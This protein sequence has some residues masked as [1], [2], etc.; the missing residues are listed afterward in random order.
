MGTTT[1]S[2][3]S[4]IRKGSAGSALAV[5][6]VLAIS[7]TSP[8]RSA[9]VTDPSVCIAERTGSSVS[10]IWLDAGGHHV[11]RRDG[12]Y[13]ADVGRGVSG[14]T[15]QA[16][17]D[18]ATYEVRTWDGGVR[19]DRTCAGGGAA[20]G[21]P[22]GDTECWVERAGAT[23]TVRWID[24]GGSHVVRRNGAWLASPGSGVAAYTDGSATSG[25][26]YEVR[27]WRDGQRYDRSCSENGTAPTPN[28]SP[29][30]SSGSA[31]AERVIHVSIDG[32]RADHVTPALMPN[33]TRL[34]NQG[35]STLNARTD[36]A[37]TQTLPNHTSMFTGRPV[38]GGSGH[39]VDYNTDKGKTVHQETGGYVASVFDV[40][41]DRGGST[42]VYAGKSKFDMVH[43]T[44][45]NNGAADHVG[46]NNGRDKIDEYRQISPSAAVDRLR[47]ALKNRGNLEYVFFHIRNPDNAGHDHN[48][49]S[50]QYRSAVKEADRILGQ[51]VSMIEGNSAW[52]NATAIIVVA[53]HG[54][55]TGQDLHKNPALG[56]NYTIPFVVWGPG[57]K[58]GADLY[59]LNSGDR[60]N[61][62][63]A[64]VWLGGIQ[65]IRNGEVANLALDF[66][67]YP[68]VPGSTH[69]K[70]Q[71]LDVN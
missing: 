21:G 70:R 62:G 36:P 6:G 58:P 12:A 7:G 55:P 31:S 68:A 51:V 69:N 52:R 9:S 33:L 50:P 40:V 24:N 13:L 30:P 41:H 17:P 66:L 26:T 67:G 15:D 63:S 53:D 20:N 42:S 4:L 64:R 11:I 5:A 44:W 3:P 57:V 60:K 59:A 28:P 43:R 32:L 35:A 29:T 54:G 47:T 34:R 18:G 22:V 45:G 37:R 56:G 61:P 71:D 1:S 49:G 16:A 10:L 38:D 2:R 48:W 8:V 23:A 14:Y 25:S 46:A 39:G 27:T 19:T 65:P